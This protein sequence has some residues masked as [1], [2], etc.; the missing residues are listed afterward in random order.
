MWVV[1]QKKDKNI[2]AFST[3]TGWKDLELKWNYITG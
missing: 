2:D 3:V 1:K